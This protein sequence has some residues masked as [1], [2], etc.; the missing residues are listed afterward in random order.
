MSSRYFD[1]Y[2]N[3]ILHE[4]DG[5]FAL[6]EYIQDAWYCGDGKIHTVR[7]GTHG[8]D[9]IAFSDYD[10]ALRCYYVC[11]ETYDLFKDEMTRSEILD[12]SMKRWHATENRNT[13]RH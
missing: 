13:V 7:L 6:V 9:V 2:N 3:V 10:T 4:R 5:M 8:E 11:R 12:E 1:G